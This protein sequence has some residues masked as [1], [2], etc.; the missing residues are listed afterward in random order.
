MARGV[1][2]RSIVT[3]A[4]GL[5]T[6]AVVAG[7]SRW[8]GH[9]DPAG[10]PG[11]G[12]AARVASD[13]VRFVFLLT[14]AAGLIWWLFVLTGREGR[15]SGGRGAQRAKRSVVERLMS[16]LVVAVIIVLAFLVARLFSS[17]GGQGVDPSRAGSTSDK[18]HH[19]TTVAGASDGLPLAGLVGVVVVVGLLAFWWAGRGQRR[20]SSGLVAP[21]EPVAEAGVAERPIVDVDPMTETDPRGVVLACY[22]RLMAVMARHGLARRASEAP[23]EHLDR[24]LGQSPTALTPARSLARDFEVARFSDHEISPS[25]SQRAVSSLAA[26]M[27]A[28]RGIPQ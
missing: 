9:V 20:S 16:F 21:A 6:V 27:D 25:V 8:L 28:L 3:L 18:A 22:E 19:V 5:V 7:A 11:A 4:I 24:V 23:F 1:S 14:C 10:S 17:P 2:N 15:S 13:L 12:A 26:A